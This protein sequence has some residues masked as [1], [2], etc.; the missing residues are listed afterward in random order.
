MSHVYFDIASVY[1]PFSGP[2]LTAVNKNSLNDQIRVKGQT[3]YV[4][5]K[6]DSRGD[7]T[8]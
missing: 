8:R 1:F 2:H 6:F 7:Q 5:L 3:I 4:D